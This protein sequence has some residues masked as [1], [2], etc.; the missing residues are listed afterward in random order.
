[1]LG[2]SLGQVLLQQ[3]ARS[4][5]KM[6]KIKIYLETISELVNASKQTALSVMAKFEDVFP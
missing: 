1:M 3:L 5:K 6:M 4:F 2:T